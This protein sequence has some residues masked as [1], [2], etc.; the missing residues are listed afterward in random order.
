MESQSGA[1]HEASQRTCDGVFLVSMWAAYYTASQPQQN[2]GRI[3]WLETMPPRSI[4]FPSPG[5]LGAVGGIR[6]PLE[7]YLPCKLSKSI[8]VPWVT[9]GLTVSPLATSTSFLSVARYA[10]IEPWT[11]VI[12]KME[13][14]WN[15]L[16]NL[17]WHL[18]RSFEWR[19][20]LKQRPIRYW[21]K[22]Y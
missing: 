3:F 14:G 22:L 13:R 16:Q 10:G 17:N 11:P 18:D 7:N 2:I 9:H 6:D 19:I 5:T 20:G 4:V 15:I 1:D 21:K 12:R 8:P